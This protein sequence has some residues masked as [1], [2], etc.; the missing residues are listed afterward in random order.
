MTKFL[1][2]YFL[3]VVAL[4]IFLPASA[5]ASLISGLRCAESSRPAAEQ[6]CTLNDFVRIAVNVSQLI[7]G[8]TGSIALLAFIYGGF[9][10]L[11]SGGSAQNVEKGKGILKAAVIGLVI[12]FASYSIIQFVLQSADLVRPD[13]TFKDQQ[14]KSGDWNTP[15][16]GN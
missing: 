16:S 15:P 13:G 2:T 3:I 1:K 11:L 9:V 8:L 4:I 10:F 5:N 14:I 7:L 12:V 6:V